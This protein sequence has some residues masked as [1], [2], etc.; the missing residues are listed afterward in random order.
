M[1]P[2]NKRRKQWVE[3]RSL[4]TNK[5]TRTFKD[6]YLN[7]LSRYVNFLGGF[8]VITL[9]EKTEDKKV[10]VERSYFLNYFNEEVVVMN[11][12]GTPQ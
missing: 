7:R 3:V 1:T 10:T 5:I 12:E 6:K 8:I 4:V 11:V 2:E 9:D